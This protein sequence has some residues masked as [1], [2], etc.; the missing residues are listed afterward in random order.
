MTHK[1]IIDK[2]VN[3]QN[4]IADFTRLISNRQSG[5]SLDELVHDSIAQGRTGDMGK[6][7][8]RGSAITIGVRLL[9][10]CFYMLGYKYKMG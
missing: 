6:D 5:F 9:Q 2:N 4:I 3:S 10:A 8:H 1:W 7:G